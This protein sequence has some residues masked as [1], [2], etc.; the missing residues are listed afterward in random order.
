MPRG[1]WCLCDASRVR[2]K[3]FLLCDDARQEVGGTLTLVGV[4]NERILVRTVPTRMDP[5]IELPR[6]A[7]VVVVAG[8]RRVEMVAFRI[9]TRRCEDELPEAPA[10]AFEAH[11]PAA[12]EH[13]FVLVQ[14]PLRLPGPGAYEVVF[15]VD[16]GGTLE[17]FR[18]NFRVETR[19][20]PA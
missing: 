18:C 12:D 17:T 6:L 2:L 5:I 9:R 16:A 19:W 20:E 11:D 15:E 7:V 3:A 1:W 13:N 14:A 4:Y 8:L 10:L